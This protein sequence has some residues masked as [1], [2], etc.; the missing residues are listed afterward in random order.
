MENGITEDPYVYLQRWQHEKAMEMLTDYY[1][2][3][4]KID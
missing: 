3:G 2:K 4:I 1:K